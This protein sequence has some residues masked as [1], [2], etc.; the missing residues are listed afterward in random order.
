MRQSA[1]LYRKCADVNRAL[2]R[3]VPATAESALRVEFA[4]GSRVISLPGRD[5]GA[6]RGFSAPKLV[7]IDEA[8]RVPDT[9]YF[10]IRPML[11]VSRGRL[12]ALSTPIGRRGWF[13]ESYQS[14]ER[15][16]RVHVTADQIPRISKEFLGE[17]LEALG[18]AWFRQEYY[19][20]FRDLIGACFRQ[21]DIDACLSDDV[22]P[23]FVGA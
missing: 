13:Y 3:P 9:L 4:N 22:E 17:E 7:I 5:D 16:N 10:S 8:S 18:E 20:E 23:L 19:C 14:E 6:I 1:E 15:W 12:L 11:S 2:G 21:E